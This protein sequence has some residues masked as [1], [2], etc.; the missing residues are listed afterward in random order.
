MI[1]IL[2]H[3]TAQTPTLEYYTRHTVD[4]LRP[5]ISSLFVTVSAAPAAAQQAVREKYSAP[6][7]NRVSAIEVRSPRVAA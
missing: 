6:K 2:T 5:L 1:L 4:S 3:Y 7:F